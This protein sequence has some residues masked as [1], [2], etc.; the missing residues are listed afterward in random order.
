MPQNRDDE[1]EREIRSHLELEAEEGVAD[2]MSTEEA[3]YAALRAFGNVTRV[4]ETTREIWRPPW[5]EHVLQDLSYAIRMC[6]RAPGLTLIATVTLALAIGANT[7]VFSLLNALVLRDLPV[8]NPESLVHVST[9][10]RLQQEALSDLP[11]VSGTGGAAA[12][13]QRRHRCVGQHSRDRQ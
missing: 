12:G 3:R 2:G 9:T 5:I 6:R 10:T 8:R 4:R 11:D 1:L 7:A 13:L